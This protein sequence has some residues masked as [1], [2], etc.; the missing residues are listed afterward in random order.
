MSKVK[1]IYTQ[2]QIARDTLLKLKFDFKGKLYSRIYIMRSAQLEAKINSIREEIKNLGGK[3][4]IIRAKFIHPGPGEKK[5]SK[6]ELYFTELNEDEVKALIKFRYPFALSI[7]TEIK[8][9]L[10]PSIIK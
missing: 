1:D 9:C 4:V 5:L 7:E 8:D 6:Y 3:H 10:V 2:L